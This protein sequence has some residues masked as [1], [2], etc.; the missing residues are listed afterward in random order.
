MHTD[1]CGRNSDRNV[2]QKEVGKKAK[3]QDLMYGDTTNVEHETYDCTG[4]NWSH[5]NSNKRLK[6]SFES[7]TRKTFNRFNKNTALLVTSHIIRK[8]LQSETEV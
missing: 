4:N 5:R 2:L 3:I 8:V 7:H 1:R 6:E